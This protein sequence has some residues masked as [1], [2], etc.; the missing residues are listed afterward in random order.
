[1]NDRLYTHFLVKK[2]D[3]LTFHLLLGMCS[4]KRQPKDAHC[5]LMIMRQYHWGILETGSIRRLDVKNIYTSRVMEKQILQSK[6]SYNLQQKFDR[7]K[8]ATLK[9]NASTTQN[10]ERRIKIIGAELVQ[11]ANI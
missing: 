1:M 8:R 5:D 4:L 9:L 10:K 7:R 6:T 2:E 11:P 3:K